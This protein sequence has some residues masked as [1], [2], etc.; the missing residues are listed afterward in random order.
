MVKFYKT[1][2]NITIYSDSSVDRTSGEE[3]TSFFHIKKNNTTQY[4]QCRYAGELTNILAVNT[5][6]EEMCDIE[7]TAEMEAHL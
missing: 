5:S 3:V 4:F 1:L 6:L 7:L 2:N